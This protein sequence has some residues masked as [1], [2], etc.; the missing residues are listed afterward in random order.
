M[1]IDVLQKLGLS[2]NEAKIYEALLG[3]KTA[4]VGEISS[5]AEVHRRNVY[6]T[7]SRLIEKGLVFPVISK[8]ENLY[9][10]AEPDKLLQLIENKQDKLEKVLPMLNA[11]YSKREKTQEAY[12]YKGIEGMKNYMTDILKK[13]SDTYAIG[14]Q[15][16]W[17]DPRLKTFSEPLLKEV[18]K[19]GI[20]FHFVIDEGIKEKAPDD[21]KKFNSN[22]KI[23]PKKYCSNSAVDICGD[24]VFSFSGLSFKKIEDDV[25]IFILRDKQLAESYRTWFQFIYDH[26]PKQTKPQKNNKN[27]GKGARV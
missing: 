13:G 22:Y 2:L 21:L 15:L 1:P 25:T 5:K 10:P 12:I 6:D 20:K 4:G 27:P 3:L 17:L 16:S 26:C 19:R 8:G 7:L 9:S 11:K 14:V 24:Y 23:L 18:K